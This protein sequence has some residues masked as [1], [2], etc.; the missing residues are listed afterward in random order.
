MPDAKLLPTSFDGHQLRYQDGWHS[1]RPSP[2]HQVPSME[3]PPVP[4]RIENT[5]AGIMAKMLLGMEHEND[6]SASGCG[7]G[8]FES[9]QADYLAA[10]RDCPYGLLSFGPAFN[11]WEN[12]I[13]KSKANAP[14]TSHQ[15]EPSS[16]DYYNQ[17]PLRFRSRYQFKSR[18]AAPPTPKEQIATTIKKLRHQIVKKKRKL[19]NGFGFSFDRLVAKKRQQCASTT[20]GSSTDSSRSQQRSRP[21]K[22]LTQK[23]INEMIVN[24]IKSLEQRLHVLSFQCKD[25]RNKR[26]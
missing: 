7:G 2:Q 5:V 18:Y 11:V 13:Q 6:K 16:E 24:E 22:L 9:G 12:E 20:I 1:Y 10:K 8:E 19:E 14:N 17:L 21:S 26:I 25:L 4:T 15:E 3:N 23:Q